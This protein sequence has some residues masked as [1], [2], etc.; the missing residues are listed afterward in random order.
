MKQ[1]NLLK[2]IIILD[3]AELFKAINS[4][5]E[6]VITHSGEIKFTPELPEDMVVY[7]GSVQ[8]QSSSALMPTKP[9]SLSEIFGTNYK[10]VE[11]EDRVLV[12]AAG[13]WQ[14]IIGWNNVA[15][16]Y[17]DTSPDGVDRFGDKELE[18]MGWHGT[19]FNIDYRDIV[20]ELEAKVEG[21]ILCIEHLEPNYQFSGLGYVSNMPQARTVM[22]DF[23]KAH[24]K[25]L[26]EGESEFTVDNLDD[27]EQEAAE[28]F[29]LI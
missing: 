5:K 23:C 26:L 15:S 18:K 16:T 10:I 7:K 21:V 29:K 24:I 2:E 27:D 17:D 20:N 14:D 6:F 4:T 22:F 3:R 1:F 12:K 8:P 25:A 11:D 13:A 19:D 9:K 28:Y